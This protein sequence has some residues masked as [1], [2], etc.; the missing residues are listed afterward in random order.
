[1][2]DSESISKAVELLREAANPRKIILF[3]SYATG[4]ADD[5]SDVD[6]LVVEDQVADIMAEMVRLRR[7]VSPLRIPADVVVINEA[8]YNYWSDTPGNLMFEVALEGEV[9]YEAA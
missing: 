5:G 8:Y 6:L 7:V 4:D 1:M 9:L 3:G 2:I